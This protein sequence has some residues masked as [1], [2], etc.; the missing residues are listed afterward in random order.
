MPSSSQPPSRLCSSSPLARWWLSWVEAVKLQGIIFSL[1]SRGKAAYVIVLSVSAFPP[2]SLPLTS[3]EPPVT[4]SWRDGELQDV[5][6]LHVSLQI[7]SWGHLPQ[8]GDEDGWQHQGQQE[9]LGKV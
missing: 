1:V 7:G 2:T 8:G 9:M 5:T 6:F 4:F 3:F